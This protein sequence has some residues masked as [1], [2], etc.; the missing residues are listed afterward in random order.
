MAQSAVGSF[1][2]TRS[3]VLQPCSK[4][5]TLFFCDSRV[6]SVK[7]HTDEAALEYR[8]VIPPNDNNNNNHNTTTATT[9]NIIMIQQFL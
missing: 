6:T 9:T 2:Q 7:M 4:R 5:S 1:T 3:A 8:T